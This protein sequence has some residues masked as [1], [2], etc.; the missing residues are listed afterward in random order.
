LDIASYSYSNTLQYE[1]D[2]EGDEQQG[3]EGSEHKDHLGGVLSMSGEVKG[4]WEYWGFIVFQSK[5]EE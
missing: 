5:K 2:E 4:G 1:W 3:E